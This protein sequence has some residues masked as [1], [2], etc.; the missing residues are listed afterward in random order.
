MFSGNCTGQRI[1]MFSLGAQ[2]VD[3]FPFTKETRTGRAHCDF[4]PSALL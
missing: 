4:I 3:Q 2:R 1:P